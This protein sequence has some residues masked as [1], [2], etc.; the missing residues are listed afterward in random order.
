MTFGGRL[1][2]DDN[3]APKKYV[4]LV[5]HKLEDDFTRQGVAP[6]QRLGICIWSRNAPVDNYHTFVS[7][8]NGTEFA[9]KLWTMVLSG[10][11][12][13]YS[14]SMDE[15]FT[16]QQAVELRQK[17]KFPCDIEWFGSFTTASVF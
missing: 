17:S 1:Y 2:L 6:C 13:N 8:E 7:Q 16:A 15:L 14:D 5:L 9:E 4:A 3:I 12:Q 10:E 11:P